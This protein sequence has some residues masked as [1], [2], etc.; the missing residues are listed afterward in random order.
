MVIGL[1][2][3]MSDVSAGHSNKYVRCKS[4]FHSLGEWR[5][6]VSY[7]VAQSGT[8]GHSTAMVGLVPQ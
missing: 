1:V 7:Q 8:G 6:L 5:Y 2:P 3:S 4:N